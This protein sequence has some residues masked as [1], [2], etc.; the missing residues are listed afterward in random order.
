MAGHAAV[1]H[2][3]LGVGLAV[4]SVVDG[5]GS[6]QPSVDFPWYLPTAHATVRERLRV[7]DTVP[8]AVE[9]DANCVALDAR[10]VLSEIPATILALIVTESPY[11]V[12][13]GIM[14]QDRLVRGRAG[15]TGEL[16]VDGHSHSLGDL[17]TACG[18]A[19]RMIDPDYLALALPP[20]IAPHDLRY[21]HA[22]IG[23]RPVQTLDQSRAA[24]F[25]AAYLAHRKH[26]D[27]IVEG[28]V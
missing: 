21:T 19:I 25:G 16:L 22:A 27:Y 8:V 3:L 14:I 2:E 9:N 26:V 17:D 18:T 28:G 23:D 4:G 20:G 6:V 15:S 5:D 24:L 11:S 7:P 1:P 12:G 13:A 10:R